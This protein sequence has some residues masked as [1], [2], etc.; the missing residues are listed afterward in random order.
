MWQ[1]GMFSN[2]LLFPN[3]L[4]FAQIFTKSLEDSTMLISV[5]E[6]EITDT[7]SQMYSAA[8]HRES[9]FR[10]VREHSVQ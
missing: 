2:G 8:T 5:L 7:Q 6:K 4:V 3:G 1:D 9:A 10:N